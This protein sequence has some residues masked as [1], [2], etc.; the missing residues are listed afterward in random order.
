MGGPQVFLYQP[1]EVDTIIISFLQ[2]KKQLGLIE[3]VVWPKPEFKPRPTFSLLTPSA[4]PHPNFLHQGLCLH[5]LLISKGWGQVFPYWGQIFPLDLS[6]K[7]EAA[8][9]SLLGFFLQFASILFFSDAC[10]TFLILL[11]VPP[12]PSIP[13][14]SYLKKIL[15]LALCHVCPLSRK[16]RASYMAAPPVLELAQASPWPCTCTGRGPPSTCFSF[17]YT[18]LE[19]PRIPSFSY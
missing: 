14:C 3:V 5:Y 1:R 6:V 16:A 15:S 19:H 18:H 4:C 12:T 11:L 13:K 9:N 10:S 7:P 8:D 2:L 17:T